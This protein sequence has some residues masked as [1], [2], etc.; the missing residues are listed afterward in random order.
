VNRD[1]IVRLARDNGFTFERKA[2][3]G[4]FYVDANKSRIMIAH[5]T[6]Y[7]DLR[8][9]KN[10]IADINRAVKLRPRL[11]LTPIELGKI[12]QA[13]KSRKREIKRQ[14]KLASKQVI[15]YKATVLPEAVIDILTSPHLNAEQKVRMSLAYAQ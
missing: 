15:E 1:T 4:E 10:S 2:L 12:K 13:E 8:A 3:H 7:G 11:I 6:G 5:S 9:Y 14:L